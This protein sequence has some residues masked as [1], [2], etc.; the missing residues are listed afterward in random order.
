MSQNFQWNSLDNT[1]KVVKNLQNTNSNKN[2]I[3]ILS[4][5][6]EDEMLQKVLSYTYDSFKKYGISEDVYNDIPVA[7]NDEFKY[8]VSPFDLLDELSQ[9]NINDNLRTLTKSYIELAVPSEYRE[10]V[11]CM[12]FK[13][14]LCS[15]SSKT[16][17]KVWSTL[18]P[19]WEISQGHPIKKVKTFKNG[20]KYWYQL[21]LNGER[22]T[23][24]V[25]EIKSRQNHTYEGLDHIISDL[26]I[27]SRGVFGVDLKD[28]V[29]DGELIN[30][31]RNYEISDEENF[32]ITRSIL[33][34]KD[35]DKT[36]IEF[37]LFD[38]LTKHEFDTDSSEPYSKRHN[39]LQL[40]QEFVDK[41]NLQHIRI[42]P[43]FHEGVVEN[44]DINREILA[45]LQDYVDN[46][47]K[48]EGLMVQQ[49]MPYARK[50]SN[51]LLKVKT[52]FFNDCEVIGYVEGKGKA[53]GT[54][55]SLI[56]DYK[57]YP[58]GVSSFKE[59]EG[60]WIWEHREE[61]IGR[62][63]CVKCK[64]ETK[65]EKGGVSM[66]FPKFQHICEVGKKV[67]YES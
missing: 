49:D 18:L 40:I 11:K 29:F 38:V 48:C 27:I 45:K 55:G 42:V 1:L 23:F 28:M 51:N 14:L 5:N 35:N 21:K 46:E 8:I 65:N 16:V 12:L 58:C 59:D 7:N 44:K 67:S 37:V 33:S 30:K 13:D 22:G 6:Y 15:I 66:Q 32:R 36:P 50:R 2:K 62:V 25:N 63:I 39:D 61:M 60:N 4:S 17:T 9:K 54:I 34:T 53:K 24:Y 20:R 19:T 43:T 41:N 47:L 56:V 31:N 26:D 64:G 10:L 57:G 3:A 52:F